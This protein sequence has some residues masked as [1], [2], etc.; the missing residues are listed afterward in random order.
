MVLPL[1]TEH[2]VCT[3]KDNTVHP[4]SDKSLGVS[5]QRF[6]DRIPNNVETFLHMYL[7]W[8]WLCSCESWSFPHFYF[9]VW[10][11][12]TIFCKRLLE[13][14]SR[15]YTHNILT[16]YFFLHSC[17]KQNAL[18]QNVFTKYIHLPLLVCTP[19][20]KLPCTI[21]IRTIL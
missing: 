20:S 15:L 1:Y 16:I 4:H 7:E 5:H 21:L 6:L 10:S 11:H 3:L 17:S 14:C 2:L 19:S 12:H 13:I 9:I 18:S 8:Q